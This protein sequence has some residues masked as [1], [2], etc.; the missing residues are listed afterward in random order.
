VLDVLRGAPKGLTYSEV[1]EQALPL[2]QSNA[3]NK[4]KSVGNVLLALKRRNKVAFHDGR[5]YAP[6]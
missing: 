4:A 3:T 1:V 6:L 5:Y 2:V